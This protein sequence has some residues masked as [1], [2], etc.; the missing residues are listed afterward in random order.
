[1][2]TQKKKE[3]METVHP[4]YTTKTVVIQVVMCFVANTALLSSGMTLG[5][6]AVALPYML[7]EN[8]ILVV[9]K[10]QASWIASLAAIATPVGCLISGP[11][12]DKYGRR[13][14]LLSLNI[15]AFIGWLFVCISP[16]FVTLCIGRVLTGIACGLSSIPATVYIAESTTA[17]IRGLLVVGTSI[18][19]S[20]G[21]AIVYILG[22]FIKEN[23]PLVAGICSIFPVIAGV[24]IGTILPESPAWLI[25]KGKLE[26]ATSSLKFLRGTDAVADIQVELDDMVSK[27]KSSQ[28]KSQSLFSNIKAMGRPEG[29]KPLIIM[30]L[31]FFFQQMTGVFVV[32]FYA[33]DVVKEAGVKTDPF[34][35]AV[36][37][38]L[39]RLVFTVFAAWMS[40][41]FGR[42]PTA[43]ISGVGMTVSLLT[44]A[45]F[46]YSQATPTYD[47]TFEHPLENNFTSIENENTT[48]PFENE[49]EPSL[50]PLISIMVYILASTLGFL[51]LPWAMIGEVFPTKIRGV[52]S[53][54]TTCITYMVSFVAVKIYPSM[55]ESLNKHGVFFFY[56]AMALLGTIFVIIWLPE[57]QGKTLAEIE[58]LFRGKSKRKRNKG[59]EDDEEG[60]HSTKMITIVS[61]NK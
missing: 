36:M 53:G 52:A 44:L 21:V 32:I 13:K 22:L 14:G 15:P 7:E 8:N 54:L 10:S 4:I 33:V 35:V 57:T 23:W 26:D 9:N 3:M 27:A 51:T 43:I 28:S 39:I 19:I 12:I 17:S 48:L 30:N 38:G 1:M 56:G 42:R 5:F 58:D 2:D 50:V 49:A 59:A 11:I 6:T 18:A 37:I 47:H 61:S 25:S 60:L 16:S 40:R 20:T 41:R 46:L 45:S 31:F 29:Y 34:L 24:M 55:L